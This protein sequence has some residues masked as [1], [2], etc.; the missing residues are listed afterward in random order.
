MGITNEH[1]ILCY[2]S[3]HWQIQNLVRQVVLHGRRKSGYSIGDFADPLADGLQPGD[4][5][6]VE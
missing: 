5:R 1:R 6:W 3:L 2:R 4:V